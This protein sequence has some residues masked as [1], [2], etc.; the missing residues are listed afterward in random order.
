MV[1]VEK[2]KKRDIIDAEKQKPAVPKSE[3][4][5]Q[6]KKD[7]RPAVFIKDLTKRSVKIEEEKEQMRVKNTKSVKPEVSDSEERK[8]V[9]EQVKKLQAAIDCK[10]VMN[11]KEQIHE[12]KLVQLQ[13]SS[14]VASVKLTAKIEDAE[15]ELL[16]K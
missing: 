12:S 7:L 15:C 16:S 1:Y 5:S 2:S 8:K 9:N 10:D 6:S 4:E 13:V 14:D 3:H 11:L